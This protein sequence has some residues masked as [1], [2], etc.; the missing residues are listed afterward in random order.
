MPKNWFFQHIWQKHTLGTIVFHQSANFMKNLSEKTTK[1]KGKVRTKSAKTTISGIFPAFS[2][3]NEFSSKIGLG[4]VLSIA[5][6]HL[7]GK[8]QKKL[9]MKSQ[10]NAQKPVF[11]AYFRHLRHF[12]PEKKVFTKSDSAMI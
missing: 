11:P 10:E 6:A 4:H 2:A 5:N 12:R 3:G 8:N 7:Y 1:Y 9:M